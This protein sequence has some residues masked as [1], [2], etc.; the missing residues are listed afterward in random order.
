[1]YADSASGISD[2]N[3]IETHNTYGA[4]IL[5]W[6]TSGQG[7]KFILNITPCPPPPLYHISPPCTPIPNASPPRVVWRCFCWFWEND[8]PGNAGHVFLSFWVCLV[9][10]TYM[11]SDILSILTSP[12]ESELCIK[13]MYIYILHI[14][15]YGHFPHWPMWTCIPWGKDVFFRL[16]LHASKAMLWA[17]KQ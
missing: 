16:E 5:L 7:I 4:M 12:S 11:C 15:I 1:M 3:S 6:C 13:Y 17:C 10:H 9:K 8:V 2:I 14:Y